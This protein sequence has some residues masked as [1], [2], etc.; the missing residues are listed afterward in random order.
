VASLLKQDIS[1]VTGPPGTGKSQV[2]CSTVANVR[3]L[4]QSLIFA[5]RNHKA[6]DA[7]VSRL[8]DEE[9]G[10]LIL[11]TNS[12]DDSTVNITFSHAI[13]DL[14]AGTYEPLM[15]VKLEMVLKEIRKLLSERGEKA[16]YANIIQL[17]HDQIGELE[18]QQS[19]LSRELPKEALNRIDSEPNRFPHRAVKHIT[20]TVHDFNLSESKA[21]FVF[22]IFQYLKILILM[23][24]FVAARWAL[25][26]Y[27][28]LPKMPV[29]CKP[30]KLRTLVGDMQILKGASDYA[31]LRIKIISLEAKA[32]EL[33]QLEP[34]TSA[35]E[36]LTKRLVKLSSVALSLHLSSRKGLPPDADREE[37]AG[38][39]AALKTVAARMAGGEL[40]DQARNLLEARLPMLIEPVQYFI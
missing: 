8:N 31:R 37:L 10:T 27:P 29:I 6:I 13:R 2:V 16:R 7:V 32:R 19:Y 23:P 21:L 24:W 12:R 15:R 14:L 4:G 20:K 40:Q 17:H 11:R 5:S 3:L 18:Q 1:V 36:V 38:L 35:I 25:K 30:S 9:R 22:R 34:F 39:L 26:N 33:P 28:G